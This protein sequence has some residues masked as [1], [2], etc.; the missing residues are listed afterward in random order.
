MKAGGEFTGLEVNV[1]TDADG[2]GCCLGVTAAV[3]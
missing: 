2:R 1:D 3:L